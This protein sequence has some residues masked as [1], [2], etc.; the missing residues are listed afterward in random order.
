VN[1]VC[2]H[3]NQAELLSGDQNGNVRV[4]DLAANACSRE[5]VPDGEVAIRSVSVAP[6]GSLV[7]AANNRGHVFIWRLGEEDTSR[8]D[9]LQRLDAHRAY[10]LRCL[11]SPD[12]RLLATCSAD[13]TVKLWRLDVPA[14]AAASATKSS[15]TQPVPLQQQQQQQQQLQQQPQQREFRSEKTLSG[16]ARW[17]WDAVFSA[18]SAYLVTASS[19]NSARLWDLNAGET[20]R[21]Y[22][23]HHKAVTAIALSD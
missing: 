20:I 19:D 23:G 9:P 8:F 7:A 10:I 22:T 5:L 21:T 15:R 1:S 18:D 2:L 12:S 14:A 11:F 17:V 4:W 6:D 16:H 3:P 13:H